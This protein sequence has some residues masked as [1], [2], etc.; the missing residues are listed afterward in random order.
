MASSCFIERLQHY[1]EL[2]ETEKSCLATLEEAPEDFTPGE[3]V[4]HEDRSADEICIVQSGWLMSSTVL[5]NGQRQILRFYFPGDLAGVTSIAFEKTVAAVSAVDK[6]RLCRFPRSSLREIFQTH[7][8][9]AAL[10]YTIGM[11]ENVDLSDRLRALGRTSGKAR[12]AQ[13]LLSTAARRKITSGKE[14]SF[15]TIPLTQADLADAVG[16]TKVHV[17]R[18]LRQ[19]TEEGMI[20]RNRKDFTLARPDELQRIAHFTNRYET[21]DTSWFPPAT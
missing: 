13:F 4:F 11:V 10:F 8:R 12:I 14:E 18:L 19:M 6:A 16:L 15:I 17:N 2:T 21:M 7:P 3:V 5:P 9:L 1:L 20:E